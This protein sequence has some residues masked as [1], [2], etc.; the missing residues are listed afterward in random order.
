MHR[1]TADARFRF[2][3][4][5]AAAAEAAAGDDLGLDVK[6]YIHQYYRN[7]SLDDLKDRE[8]EDLAGA[9]LSHLRLGAPPRT[10]HAAHPGVQPVP[11]QQRLELGAHHRA[12]RQ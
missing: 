1:R 9:A 8:V 5:V 7:T 6:A 11:Q 4:Q 2:L 3:E 10:G 12:G